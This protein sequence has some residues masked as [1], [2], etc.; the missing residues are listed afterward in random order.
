MLIS[1]KNTKRFAIM[2][3]LDHSNKTAYS[4]HG[5]NFTL[6]WKQEVLMMSTSS[7]LVTSGV[8]ITRTV[9]PASADKFGIAI[10]SCFLYSKQWQRS[11]YETTITY[12]QSIC[13]VGNN[14]TV[15]LTITNG[16]HRQ[17]TTVYGK[18]IKNGCPC[19]VEIRGTQGCALVGD[20]ARAVGECRD[21]AKAQ[22]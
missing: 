12:Y 17:R 16:R 3:E 8:A 5:I 19:I 11:L 10:F 4:S 2:T 15:F 18:G 6:H 7:S 13:L 20:P 22:P 9:F 14:M 21:V 1:N